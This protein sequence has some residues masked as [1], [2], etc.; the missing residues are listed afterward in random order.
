M[1]EQAVKVYRALGDPTRYRIVQMLA[2]AE[3][4]GCGDFAEAFKLSAPALSH[5]TRVLQECGLISMRKEGPHHFFRLRR[6]QL[7]RF[8]PFLAA[9]AE[10][11]V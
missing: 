11:G 6:E 3:E 8:A 10:A 5:H 4:L 1:D 9:R 2:R 7:A